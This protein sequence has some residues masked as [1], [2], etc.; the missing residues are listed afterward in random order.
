MKLNNNLILLFFNRKLN[1]SRYNFILFWNYNDI[2]RTFG[3]LSTDS[4]MLCNIYHLLVST[5]FVFYFI[6]TESHELIIYHIIQINVTSTFPTNKIISQIFIAR[7]LYNS[8][9]FMFESSSRRKYYK[10]YL[11]YGTMCRLRFYTFT[12]SKKK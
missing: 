6:S 5:N 2:M 8:F 3:I 10:L 7:E 12:Y 4:W 9:Q 1:L 11:M